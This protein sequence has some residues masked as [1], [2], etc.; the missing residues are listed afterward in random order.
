MAVTVQ[1]QVD[2]ERS[3]CGFCDE[4]LSALSEG[5]VVSET[6]EEEG[7]DLM[8]TCKDIFV[9]NL[10]VGYVP[11]VCTEYR[12]DDRVPR[13]QNT[14]EFVF[15][16][17]SCLVLLFIFGSHHIGFRSPFFLRLQHQQKKTE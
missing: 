14:Q 16:D 12:I 17:S 9:F 2:E 1:A 8:V 3:L 6:D 5:I 4:G 15:F 7:V 10:A 13:H 11:F